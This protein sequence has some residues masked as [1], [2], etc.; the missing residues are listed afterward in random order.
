MKCK[1]MISKGLLGSVSCVDVRYTLCVANPE[2]GNWRRKESADI[3]LD[4]GYHMLD[5]I[6][7][8]IGVPEEIYGLTNEQN[9][10]QDIKAGDTCSITFRKVS[11]D[12]KAVLGNIFL[13]RYFH[14]KQELLTITGTKGSIV[15]KD[16][17]V[18][19]HLD[20][21]RK[22]IEEQQLDCEPLQNVLIQFMETIDKADQSP[23]NNSF[24]PL[25]TMKFVDA[26]RNNVNSSDYTWPVIT[27]A[28]R[29][30]VNHQ[31]SESV[32][33]YDKSGILKNFEDQFAAYHG[34]KHGLLSNSGTN[35]IFSM[36]FG[37]GLQPGD[38]IIVPVYTFFATA[39]PLAHLGVKVVLR[40][41]SEEVVILIHQ[42]FR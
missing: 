31:L 22:V 25:L 5:I 32:S 10:Y 14:E 8:L 42:K 38:E 11:E 35:A 23:L 29:K 18:F 33:I 27:S 40:T 16:G 21:E 2:T 39:S 3:V 15:I 36:F 24:D 6:A 37:L 4:M 9:H 34:R 12:G 41:V 26:L 1:D 30:A 7:W 19:K 20:P 28:A 17:Q 13:A